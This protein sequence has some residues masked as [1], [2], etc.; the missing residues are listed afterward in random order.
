MNSNNNDY[1]DL[2]HDKRLYNENGN[3][4]VGNNT[5]L[6][7]IIWLIIFFVAM[8]GLG[9]FEIQRFKKDNK[10]SFS[11]SYEVNTYGSLTV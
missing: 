3:V 1:Q 5:Q 11:D 2:N 4:N 10:M 8:V 9:L 6:I 7:Y